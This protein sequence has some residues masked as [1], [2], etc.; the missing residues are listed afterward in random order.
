VNDEENNPKHIRDRFKPTKPDFRLDQMFE[1]HSDEWERVGLAVDVNQRSVQNARRRAVLE[2]VL[3]VAVI[4]VFDNY[5][6]WFHLIKNGSDPH[7][8]LVTGVRIATV[9][10][11]LALGWAIAR[12]IGR[13]AGPTFFRR[14]DPG[15]AGTVG[16]LV[17]LVTVGIVVLV[18]LGVAGVSAASI[19]AGSAFT[20]V[21]LGLAAQQTLGNLFAG[22]VLLSARP[23]RVGERVRLQAGAV[24]GQLE[25]VVSSLGLLYTTLARGADR[26]MVPNNVVLSAA[27]LPIREPDSVDVRVRL[28]TGISIRQVQTILDDRIRTP[29]RRS[30]TVLLEEVD[31]NDVVVRVQATPDRPDDGAQLADEI[32]DALATV[33]G[34]HP[35]VEED[36]GHPREQAGTAARRSWSPG[37]PEDVTTD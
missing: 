11:L 32:I 13:I 36:E 16:F 8:G 9:L 29:T 31:G 23:F 21:I 3:F 28:G 2:I 19:V 17:R 5:E 18:V 15:T 12:D 6:H 33:T 7:T 35:I 27:V 24:A 34:E 14:M 26:I 25:G 22:M 10:A 1:T 20:A 37:G 4:V 30:P